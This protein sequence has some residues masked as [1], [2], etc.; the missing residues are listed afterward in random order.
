MSGGAAVDLGDRGDRADRAAAEDRGRWLAPPRT[1][2]SGKSVKPGDIVDG[3]QR[4]DDRGEQHRRGG[5]VGARR[6]PLPRDLLGSRAGGRPGDA[7]RRCDHRARLDLRRVDLQQ[8]RVRRERDRGR[9]ADR[10]D[11]VEAA[12]ARGVRRVGQ[13]Q[14]RRTSTTRPKAAR[15]ARSPARRSSPTSWETLPGRTSTSPVPHGIWD[16]PTS[17]RAHPGTACACWSSSRV[18]RVPSALRPLP[19]YELIRRAI[20]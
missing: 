6:L 19:D 1:C 2:P 17:A 12:A 10:R 5:T 16:V 14:I 13:G 8:R 11:R 7:D 9:G 3:L 20:R 15:R 4:Q 18:P